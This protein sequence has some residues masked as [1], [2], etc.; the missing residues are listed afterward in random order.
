MKIVSIYGITRQSGKTTIAE[1]L[2]LISRKK[3]YKTMLVDLDIHHGDVTERL[4]LERHPNI[5]D[6]C[7]NIYHRSRTMPIIEVEY[8][9]SEWTP[10]LQKHPTG[11]DV[12]ATNT[13]PKLPHYG[14]I[15]YEIK[16][17][18]NSI[19]QSD[20]QVVVFDMGNVP[21]SFNYMILEDSDYPILVVDT[22][23]YNVQALKHFIWDAEDVHF[24]VD[25]LYLLFNREPTAIEDSPENVAREFNLTLL[26]VLP[27]AKKQR[28]NLAWDEFNLKLTEIFEKIMKK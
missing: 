10:F 19:K 28:E 12:L 24:P 4:K 1:E 9:Q 26:G 25:K 23:R 11:L 7:E 14:N 15:Y 13:N 18:Y 27:E 21:T 20:Y 3:G 17:I 2:A 5:S 6:W 16:I 8:A 22:F